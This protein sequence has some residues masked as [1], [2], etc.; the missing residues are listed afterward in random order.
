MKETAI[1]LLR[2]LKPELS[3]ATPFCPYPLAA[4][5]KDPIASKNIA[6][7]SQDRSARAGG[8]AF[9]GSR[10]GENRAFPRDTRAL[11]LLVAFLEDWRCPKPAPCR[12]YALST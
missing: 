10:K 7:C 6:R 3:A 8:D 4:R 11:K 2:A 12:V 9:V 1:S 5:A